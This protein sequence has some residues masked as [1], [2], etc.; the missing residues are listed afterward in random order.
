MQTIM[1]TGQTKVAP[2]PTADA[3]KTTTTASN[4]SGKR[5]PMRQ[6]ILKQRMLIVLNNDGFP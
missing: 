3:T 4:G 5:S 2:S 1:K 6:K